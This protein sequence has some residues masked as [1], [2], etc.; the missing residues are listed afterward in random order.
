MTHTCARHDSSVVWAVWVM[1]HP[2]VCHDS[3]ICATWFITGMLAS[4][5]DSDSMGGV[6]HDSFMWK[7]WVCAMTHSWCAMTH[8]CVRH[9]SP[10]ERSHCATTL[11]ICVVWDMTQSCVCHDA[12]MRLLWLIHVCAMTHSCVCHDSFIRVP[13]FITGA[14]AA[15]NDSSYMGC[16]PIGP[17]AGSRTRWNSVHSRRWVRV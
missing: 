7:I 12:F 8:S 1:T 4:C 3:C 10:Q 5:N 11:V 2:C 16:V 15:C 13:W 6:R 9:V 14:F 17:S